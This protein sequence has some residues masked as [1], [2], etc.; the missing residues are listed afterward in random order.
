MK[1]IDLDRIYERVTTLVLGEVNCDALRYKLRHTLEEEFQG[2]SVTCDRSNNTIE[3]VMNGRIK[4]SVAQG[5]NSY[6][7][8]FGPPSPYRIPPPPSIED[9]CEALENVPTS[10]CE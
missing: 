8:Q 9:L 10:A 3:D 4:V 6:D 2:Y 1:Q 5:S 7:I